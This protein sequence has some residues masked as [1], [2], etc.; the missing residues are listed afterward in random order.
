MSEPTFQNA[1]FTEG[2]PEAEKRVRTY[3][4]KYAGSAENEGDL[5]IEIY[6]HIAGEEDPAPFDVIEFDPGLTVD[7]VSKRIVSS[8]DDYCEGVEAGKARFRVE[9]DGVR[10]SC[11][12][13]LTVPERGMGDD[14]VDE[15][16]NMKGLMMQKMRHQEALVGAN[17]KLV[18]SVSAMYEGAARS[19][20]ELAQMY[21]K[22]VEEL[23]KSHIETIKAYEDINSARH[24]RERELRKDD[25]AEKRMD[26]VAGI[27]MQ[28]APA[29]FN[30]VFGGGS[31]PEKGKIVHE[32]LTPLENQL[33][34]FMATF[35]REQLEKMASSGL[36]EPAQLMGF[37]EIAK[38]VID[39]KE[40]MDAREAA[41]RNGAPTNG[42]QHHQANGAGQPTPQSVG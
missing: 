35:N 28:G 19:W 25:K 27:L 5:Q 7:Q 3:L 36:F 18:S 10:G 16:P 30:R 39:L 20:K 2:I 11:V 13:T 23:E 9:I 14:D 4:E 29:L 41:S 32:A 17:T 37:M 31:G 24:M 1:I 22:R 42:A 21:A 40:A 33:M 12:F 38:H 8:A 15:A 6:H 34:A 26:Q